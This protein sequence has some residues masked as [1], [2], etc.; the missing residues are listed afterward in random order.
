[1]PTGEQLRIVGGAVHDPAN[2]IDGE[3]RDVCIEDGR[4]VASLPGGAPTLNANGMI[5]MPGGVDIHAHFAS[6]SCN[7]ARRLVP[8]EHSA[9]PVRAPTL[10]NGA[11]RS[12]TGGTV[13]TTFS[14]AY[15]YTGLGYTTAFDAA[16]API[17]ARHE[18]RFA[19]W[20]ESEDS[21]S[22]RTR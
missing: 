1:M 14:T 12:G 17:M 5:V 11:G 6:S 9:D 19:S 20:C 4:I 15:R 22:R 2:N 13:P 10:L 16:V 18:A 8:E 21:M 3:I 7:H